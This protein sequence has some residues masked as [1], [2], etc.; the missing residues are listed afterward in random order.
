MT[1]WIF[2]P[3]ASP[4][5]WLLHC[6]TRLI[7]WPCKQ[8]CRRR[9]LLR[10]RGECGCYGRW[11]L[12]S[13]VLLVL[14]NWRC[15]ILDCWQHNTWIWSWNCLRHR[16][17]R[18]VLRRMHAGVCILRYWKGERTHG[19]GG[20]C[21]L[22][23]TMWRWMR[24]VTEMNVRRGGM[25]LRPLIMLWLTRPKSRCGSMHRTIVWLTIR[26]VVR[27]AESLTEYGEYL[28]TRYFGTAMNS[29]GDAG[30]LRP[31]VMMKSHGRQT[32]YWFCVLLMGNK[33]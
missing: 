33:I 26:P 24:W 17:R 27:L 16:K 32:I 18:R 29:Y 31:T 20:R 12:V 11:V 3:F 8:I 22:R 15:W 9:K 28:P 4:R 5:L 19:Q 13:R 2:L 10:W 6:S 21:V 14:C 7:I 30:L 1:N 23:T 25:I